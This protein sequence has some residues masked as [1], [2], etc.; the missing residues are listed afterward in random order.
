MSRTLYAWGVVSYLWALSNSTRCLLFMNPNW[1][2]PNSWLSVF[3]ES[4][5]SVGIMIANHRWKISDIAL[6]LIKFIQLNTG[7]CYCHIL[8]VI[9][10]FTI[11]RIT[12]ITS[13]DIPIIYQISINPL[14]QMTMTIQPE[15]L[16]C[17]ELLRLFSYYT[18]RLAAWSRVRPWAGKLHQYC[19][20]N[21]LECVGDRS[22]TQGS[23][24]FCLVSI[25]KLKI[26]Y[27]ILY[28][29]W[30]LVLCQFLCCYCCSRSCSTRV[31]CLLLSLCH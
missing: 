13:F 16:C 2:L 1:A 19:Y 8:A 3:E 9:I 25:S 7:S 20:H 27:T 23:F 26:R 4:R 14:Y 30:F 18:P 24:R 15:F 5:E 28:C 12:Y 6:L 29:I 10:F 31:V 17:S 22:M 11:I 21:Q